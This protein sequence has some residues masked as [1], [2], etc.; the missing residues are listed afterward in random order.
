MS[1][2][3]AVGV[4]FCVESLVALLCLF[5]NVLMALADRLLMCTKH[6][7]RLRSACSGLLV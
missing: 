1:Q 4:Q 3:I 2:T 7:C 6:G 5:Q